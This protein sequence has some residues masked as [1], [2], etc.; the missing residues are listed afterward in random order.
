MN[1]F[2]LINPETGSP[3]TAR[4]LG[5]RQAT[6]DNRRMEY[7]KS[8][9]AEQAI[10][11]AAAVLSGMTF[12]GQ[13]DTERL[14]EVA[15]A[16]QNNTLMDYCRTH[17]ELTA[18]VKANALDDYFSNPAEARSNLPAALANKLRPPA[19][20]P[21]AAT[22]APAHAAKPANAPPPPATTPTPKPPRP[23]FTQAQYDASNRPKK[24]EMSAEDLT[25]PDGRKP[26]LQNPYTRMQVFADHQKKIVS[27]Y[28]S[29]PVAV[30]LDDSRKPFF[31]N[32][33][34]WI[35]DATILQAMQMTVSSRINAAA[36]YGPEW[37]L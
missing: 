14:R 25:R 37:Q 12:A 13:F 4:L 17:P 3:C 6:R 24:R 36:T 26:N 16:Q 20:R 23:A 7:F 35:D 21:T 8:S 9:N 10:L 11:D 28:R 32:D 27:D 34:S 22:P 5:I 2:E 1:I 15:E 29:Q 31:Y 30:A 19:T 33:S 18:A